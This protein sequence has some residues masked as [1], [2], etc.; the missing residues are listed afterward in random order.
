MS[1]TLYLPVAAVIPDDIQL[2][3][4]TSVNTDGLVH[5][6]ICELNRQVPD[7]LLLLL[8]KGFPCCHYEAR[9]LQNKGMSISNTQV[10]PVKWKRFSGNTAWIF[11]RADASR[12][13]KIAVQMSGRAMSTNGWQVHPCNLKEVASSTELSYVSRFWLRPNTSKLMKLFAPQLCPTT[14][15]ERLARSCIK[16]LIVQLLNFRQHWRIL[17]DWMVQHLAWLS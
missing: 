13:S 7:W 1:M 6:D 5:L 3:F 11:W 9:E 2:Y 16:V 4:V 17:C 14:V 10:E 12:T 15:P 8:C